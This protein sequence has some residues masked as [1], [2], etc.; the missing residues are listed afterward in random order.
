MVVRNIKGEEK[1]RVTLNGDRAH[2]TEQLAKKMC[3]RDS[4]TTKE[5]M[6]FTC[7]PPKEYPWNLF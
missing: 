5:K 1:Y 7:E 3:I 4:P 6:E 2:D